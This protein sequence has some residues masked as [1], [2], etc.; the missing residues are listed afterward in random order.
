[1]GAAAGAGAVGGETALIFFYVFVDI[2]F[3]GLEVFQAGELVELIMFAGRLYSFQYYFPSTD[4][5]AL[6]L[7]EYAAEAIGVIEGLPLFYIVDCYDEV[8]HGAKILN[9]Y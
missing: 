9:T 5:H 7:S 4:E 3:I 6:C 1:L 8:F 2:L